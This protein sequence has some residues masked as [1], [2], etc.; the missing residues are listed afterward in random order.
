MNAEAYF[1]KYYPHLKAYTSQGINPN[2]NKHSLVI[3][4]SLLGEFIEELQ[5]SIK[6][7]NVHTANGINTIVDKFD[8]QW[9]ELCQLF[10]ESDTDG[11]L[12]LNK[13]TFRGMINGIIARGRNERES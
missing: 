1:R 8:E 4:Q 7:N 3:L 9:K 5:E 13:Y 6:I 11:I 10:E 12:V 2:E